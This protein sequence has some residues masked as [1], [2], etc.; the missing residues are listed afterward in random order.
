MSGKKRKR[1]KR[2]Q[3]QQLDARRPVQRIPLPAGRMRGGLRPLPKH[4]LRRLD[5]H[6]GG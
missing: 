4:Q 5:G 1:A 6:P 2:L 3:E